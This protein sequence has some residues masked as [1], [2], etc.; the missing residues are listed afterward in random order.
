MNYYT[1]AIRRQWLVVA[2]NVFAAVLNLAIATNNLAI[3]NY[4]GLINIP[5][6]LFSAW[7]ALGCYDTLKQLEKA[8]KDEVITILSREF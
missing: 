2:L 1:T 4:I 3:G 7:V 6:G 5:V 8:S